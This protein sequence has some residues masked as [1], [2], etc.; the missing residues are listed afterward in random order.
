MKQSVGARLYDS[1]A[2]IVTDESIKGKKPNHRILL[3]EF[4]SANFLRSLKAQI[5][6]QYPGARVKPGTL[7]T[8]ASLIY[9]GVKRGNF[10]ASF[11]IT[12]SVAF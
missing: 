8:L 6:S 11:G 1:G 4:G 5:V 2:F 12:S 9:G 10:P 3:S 7:G